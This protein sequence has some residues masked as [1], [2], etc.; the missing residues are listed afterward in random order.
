MTEGLGSLMAVARAKA[1]S[2]AASIRSKSPLIEVEGCEASAAAVFAIA[3]AQSSQ[4]IQSAS[5]SEFG[6][7]SKES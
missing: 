5:C 7:G 3:S 6:L 2:V 4:V 1:G